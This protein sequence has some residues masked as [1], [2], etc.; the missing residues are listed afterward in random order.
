[1]T[2]QDIKA[3]EV[4]EKMGAGLY[5]EALKY[6]ELADASTGAERESYSR[7]AAGIMALYAAN[8]QNLDNLKGVR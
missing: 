8:R 7:M 5:A 1:M 2:T 6:A 4:T 3:I